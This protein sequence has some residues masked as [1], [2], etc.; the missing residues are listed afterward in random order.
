MLVG[1]GI[2]MRQP[3]FELG[4]CKQK[5]R[6]NLRFVKMQTSFEANSNMQES[7]IASHALLIKV[8]LGPV[9]MIFSTLSFQSCPLFIVEIL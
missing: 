5:T 9:L 1:R 8:A 4:M 3:D 2:G 7:D 6:E